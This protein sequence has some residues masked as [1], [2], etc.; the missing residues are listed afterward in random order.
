MSAASTPIRTGRLRRRLAIAFVLVGGLSAGALAVGSYLVVRHSLLA[1]S[2]D[3]ALT[4]AHVN[5]DLARS[6]LHGN[7]ADL[8]TLLHLYSSRPG[9]VTVAVLDGRHRTGTLPIPAGLH[10]LVARRNLA[11]QRE[12]VAGTPYLVVGTPT[13]ERGTTLYFFF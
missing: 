8:T 2:T 4:Q 3:R 9:F 13:S 12:T 10:R 5:L 6:T 11:Y 1:D 7:P